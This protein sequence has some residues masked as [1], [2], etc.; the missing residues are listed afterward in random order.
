MI[1]DLS[2]CETRFTVHISAS[3]VWKI[4]VVA[5]NLFLSCI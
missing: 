4:Q 3:E 2:R 1:G 5:L